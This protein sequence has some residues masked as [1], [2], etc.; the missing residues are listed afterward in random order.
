MYVK[1]E[2]ALRGDP[3]TPQLVINT[4]PAPQQAERKTVKPPIPMPRMRKLQQDCVDSSPQ[5]VGVFSNGHDLTVVD[6]PKDNHRPSAIIS[7]QYHTPLARI[8]EA[9]AYLV[10]LNQRVKE[11][12][13]RNR[14]SFINLDDRDE[15]EDALSSC[16]SVSQAYRA[17]L[18]KSA[19]Q[20]NLAQ[21]LSN[22]VKSSRGSNDPSSSG[23][24]RKKYT[25]CKSP[26]SILREQHIK[27]AKSSPSFVIREIELPIDE[28][29]IKQ[30]SSPLS[31]KSSQL[32]PIPPPKPRREEYTNTLTNAN[33]SE[34]KSLH[35]KPPDRKSVV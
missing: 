13:R 16:P 5:N 25:P 14:A 18:K 19:S 31:P 7:S 35:Q 6:S 9:T 3:H 23:T 30:S 28:Q 24:L 10:D 32:P 4:V 8:N 29:Q 1:S 20:N 21:P 22:C 26:E 15:D 12:N 11:T 2:S 33:L 17:R 27:F 34:H